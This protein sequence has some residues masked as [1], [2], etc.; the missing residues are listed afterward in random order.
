MKLL[1]TVDQYI[2][3]KPLPSLVAGVCSIGPVKGWVVWSCG[4]S[5][6]ELT[7]MGVR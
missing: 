5:A 3:G 6:L 1:K 7:V 2:R 4:L